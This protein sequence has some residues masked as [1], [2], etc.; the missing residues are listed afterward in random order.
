MWTFLK[1]HEDLE[2][3]LR[4]GVDPNINLVKYQIVRPSLLQLF[5]HILIG[6]NTLLPFHFT[7]YEVIL[8]FDVLVTMLAS[9]DHFMQ[10]W[11]AEHI[12]ISF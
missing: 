11:I 5:Q 2:H 3:N 4:H 7:L 9:I 10:S 8:T 1:M 6:Y 12:V